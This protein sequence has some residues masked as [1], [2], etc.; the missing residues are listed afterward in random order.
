MLHQQKEISQ[1]RRSAQYY[2]NKIHQHRRRVSHS[3]SPSPSLLLDEIQNTSRLLDESELSIGDI[4]VAEEL[5]ESES[6]HHH[7][8]SLTEPLEDLDEDQSTPKEYSED[9]AS[10]T[11]TICTESGGGE[12]E[13]RDTDKTLTAEDVQGQQ[14]PVKS[15]KPKI[16]VSP[17]DDKRSPLGGTRP[18]MTKTA[19]SQSS[20]SHTIEELERLAAVDPHE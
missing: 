11:A 7:N 16:E 6:H 15:M 19:K 3:P 9:F 18:R 8:Q 14:T 12:S 10:Y 2:R 20:E 5:S 4:S 13:V 17:P 1:M